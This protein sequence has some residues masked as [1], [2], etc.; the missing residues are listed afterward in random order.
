MSTM[1][2]SAAD[3]SG[4][5]SLAARL[6]AQ[7]LI[8]AAGRTKAHHRLYLPEIHG[9]GPD[10]VFDAL[11]PHLDTR[12]VAIVRTPSGA[13]TLL[14]VPTTG[15]WLVPYAV[16]RVGPN[17]GS[18][19]FAAHLRDELA[20]IAD[21]PT[22][23]LVLDTSPVETVRTA[24]EDARE[25]PQLSW[26]VLLERAAS[27]AQGA[28]ASLI[29][30]I[31]AD[32]RVADR[33]SHTGESLAT[34]VALCRD[35]PTAQIVG[36][37]LHLLGCYLSDPDAAADPARRLRRSARWR[38]QLDRWTAPGEDLA[39]KL[40]A[41][42][43]DPGDERL[44]R[45]LAAVGPFGLDF[46]GFILAD[47]PPT[48]AHDRL[49]VARPVRVLGAAAASHDDA[50]AAWLPGGGRLAILLKGQATRA[51]S[52]T[53]TWS[54]GS[55]DGEAVIDAARRELHIRCPA[56]PSGGW[57]YG[58]CILNGAE[59]MALAI[60]T[61]EGTWFPVE[62]NLDIDLDAGAFRYQADP[63]VVALNSG[64]AVMAAPELRPTGESP[65]AGDICQYS[66][67]LGSESHDIW[68]FDVGDVG[69]L[70]AEHLSGGEQSAPPDRTGTQDDSD[71]K[72]YEDQ[73]TWDR[74]GGF[75]EPPLVHASVVH[76]ALDVARG[77]MDP[78]IGELSFGVAGGIGYIGVGGTVAVL[79][80]QRLATSAT[81]TAIDGL[82]LES[83]ILERSSTMAYVARPI[84][85]GLDVE[86]DPRLDRLDLNEMGGEDVRAFLDSRSAFFS[87]VAPHGSVHA[88]LAGVA[89]QEAERYVDNYA[90]LM[91]RA[92]H[93]GPFM[94]EY[95]RLLL[96]DA[97]TDALT[98]EILIAPTNPVTVAFALQ[99]ADTALSW[100][101]R[102]SDVAD[103]DLNSCTVRH[104][105]PTFALGGV[106]YESMPGMP[107]LWRRYRPLA[108][109]SSRSEHESQY[110]TRRLK[111]FLSVYPAYAEDRQMLSVAFVEPDDGKS[112]LA[113]LRGFYQ[114]LAGVRRSGVRANPLPRLDVTLASSA[115]PPH[116]L[117]RALADSNE[118][119]DRLLRDRVSIT[120]TNTV[121]QRPRFAHLTFIFRSPLHREPLEVELNSRSSTLYVGGLATAPGRYTRPGRNETGFVWGTF[122]GAAAAPSGR[123]EPLIRMGLELVGGMPRDYV[124]PGMTRLPTTRVSS[125][126]MT[127]VY[128]RSV[129][130]VHLDRLLGLEAFAPEA[131]GSDARFLIDYDQRADP[132]QPGLDAITATARVT[133]YRLALRRALAQLG[134]SS[135]TAL[136]R[137][138]RLM[139]GVSGRWS[140]DLIGADDNALQERIGVV[141]AIAAVD[142]LDSGFATGGTVPVMV[143]LDDILEALPTQAERRLAGQY[144]DHLLYLVLPLGEERPRI[145]GRLIG[146]KYP[147]VSDVSVPAIARSQLETARARL[148]S[149][150]NSAGPRRSFR[151]RDLAEFLRSG[152][153]RAQAFGLLRGQPRREVL[154]QALER[155]ASGSYDLDLSFDVGGARALGELI[156]IEG[157]SGVAAYRQVLPG[158][159]QALTWLR[160]G[161]PV[162]EALATG[163]PLPRPS[164]LPPITVPSATPPGNSSA[165]TQP[166][167]VPP[168]PDSFPATGR[169]PASEHAASTIDPAISGQ[170]KGGVTRAFRP[171]PDSDVEV[172]R[173]SGELDQ[174]AWKYGLNVEPFEPARAEIGPSVIRFRTRL[175]GK[176]TLAAV[177]ARSL[178]LGREVGVAEGLLID[179]EPYYVT[180]DVPRAQRETIR[181]ADY[182]EILGQPGEVG[183][184]RFLVGMAPSGDIRVA[185]LARLPHLLV[186]GATNSGKS[187]FLRN[188]LSSVIRTRSPMDLQLLIC[189]PKAI[190]FQP[191]DD[192]LHLVTGHVITDPAEAVSTLTETLD[193]ELERRRALL[194]RARVT[195]ALEFYEEGGKLHELPQM[196][197]LIDEFADL[198]DA[199]S[200]DERPIFMQNV[201]RYAQ[202]A[203]ALGIYLVLATQRPSVQVITG[204]IKANLTAR[205]ALKMQ[206]S[207]D[208]VTVLGRGGAEALRDK[209]DLLFDHGGQFER[210]QGFLC[211]PRDAMAEVDRWRAR[212]P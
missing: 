127:E 135:D 89:R 210:L 175:L 151:A 7:A 138:L 130:V 94:A 56:A 11:V 37:R 48:A 59:S 193:S 24:A 155:V 32:V 167:A 179:Q 14:G 186:A 171:D 20:V 75:A 207:Q 27:A 143:P 34:L 183:A 1:P 54:D 191:F 124:T 105:L 96:C 64:G 12:P 52:A 3:A 202:M 132:G 162:L 109:A 4:H 86:A 115:G 131:T 173:V 178:D 9:M 19:G 97:V 159:G 200:R 72:E 152:V 26:A 156:S 44:R 6:V 192:L 74:T 36:A 67:T 158:H 120:V 197:I 150:F 45:V 169:Q 163:R 205:V 102:A 172:Q 73:E 198:A 58:Q 50:V 100:L 187:V 149:A 77:R 122:T 137:V 195:S 184:L 176:Q 118:P 65:E 47:M 134:G 30:A 57:R 119:V 21:V 177:Q 90:R 141:A 10:E 128:E 98:R 180:V 142:E 168:P 76:A 144:S 43:G 201:K 185:D 145:G 63:A 15:A 136:D 170:K 41:A 123:L 62:S 35:A 117:E 209:G 103:T 206:A 114:P 42:Y 93:G 80:S 104:L 111:K 139:N 146:V 189:D 16:G 92:T 39:A 126:F 5:R 71:D 85:D 8:E 22:V 99:F 164:E 212:E 161:R 84:H 17:R 157:D 13:V 108:D 87:A 29:A 78:E 83:A 68:L 69:R 129:W 46:S 140:L 106:W 18:S 33:L 133:P 25:L 181:Y 23:L 125:G 174:A 194:K 79:S 2:S 88:V 153:T 49:A 91:A 40:G 38:A 51:D 113:A 208:S 204:D 121:E 116:A 188:L 55:L 199:L 112:V 95:E 196:V 53:V 81:D 165:G 31:V 148:D 160:L 70:D 190:D 203:R 147:R 82:R 28:T 211:T 107:L 182:A 101:D 66:A 166:P 154:E 61:G 110:I 60:Y